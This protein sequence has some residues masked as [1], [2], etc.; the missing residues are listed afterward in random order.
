[1]WFKFLLALD[2]MTK[3]CVFVIKKS[4]EEITLKSWEKKVFFNGAPETPYLQFS[5]HFYYTNM[6]VLKAQLRS[7]TVIC[8]VIWYQIHKKPSPLFQYFFVSTEFLYKV[9]IKV[10]ICVFMCNLYYPKLDC[11]DDDTKL[12]W[13][14]NEFR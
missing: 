9:N 11:V 2:R 10:H 4:N 6:N 5:L 7:V 14:M 8:E 13:C 3:Y 1:M 12:M